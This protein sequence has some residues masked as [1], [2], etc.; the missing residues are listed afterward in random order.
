MVKI[1]TFILCILYHKE[2]QSTG[3]NNYT[4]P[5]LMTEWGW[6]ESNDDLHCSDR[7]NGFF[8]PVPTGLSARLLGLLLSSMEGREKELLPNKM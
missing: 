4:K 5:C 6:G 3:G 8:S 2:S 7:A 1:V